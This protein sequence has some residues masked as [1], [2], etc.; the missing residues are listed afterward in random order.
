VKNL[1]IG[2]G[3]TVALCLVAV[4]VAS[5]TLAA[6]DVVNEALHPSVYQLTLELDGQYYI[7]DFNLSRSDCHK[8]LKTANDWTG[9]RAHRTCDR[10]PVMEPQA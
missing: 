8:L 2:F 6:I 5:V 4:P 9:G 3:A 1:L 10:A 7:E